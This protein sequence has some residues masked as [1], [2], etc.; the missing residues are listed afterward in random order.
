MRRGWLHIA[1]ANAGP[2]PGRLPAA[3]DP[4]RLCII[5]LG[6]SIADGTPLT[7]DDR[8]WVQLESQLAAELPERTVVVDSWAVPG[9]RVDVLEAAARDQAALDTYDVAIVI[10]GVNDEGETPL[11]AGGPLRVRDRVGSRG[12]G[13]QV[14]VGTPP[15]AI[16]ERIVHLSI[17]PDDRGDP[18]TSR[19]RTD[20]V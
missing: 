13:L 17:R 11:D 15:P 1:A 16:R 20:A 18:T 4:G 2:T 12:A 6:D 7:G 19:F 5:V 3:D 8:W 14:I 10:E 9:S